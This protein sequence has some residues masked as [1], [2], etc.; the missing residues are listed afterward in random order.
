MTAWSM[1]EP[2]SAYD[3]LEAAGAAADDDDRVVA[4]R[5][6]TG[7]LGST[8]PSV[9]GPQAAG[10]RLEHPEHDPRI[11]DEER[12]DRAGQDEAAQ[13]ARGRR[14]RR[15]AARRA[16]STPR[17][18]SRPRPRRA[19]SV[20]VDDDRRLALE[21]DVEA[22]A[23]QALAEDALA[24]ARTAA[25]SKV[26]TIALELRGGEVGEQR[27]AA[28]ASS[29]SS[30]SAMR[31]IV[32]RRRACRGQTPAHHA[33]VTRDLD[34]PPSGGAASAR[35]DPCTPRRTDD[36]DPR[37]SDRAAGA[38]RRCSP[39]SMPPAS[40]GSPSASVEVDFPAGPCHRP[41]GRGR[42]RVLRRSPAA[43]ARRP[44]RR[45]D[46]AAGPGRLLRRAVGA[47]RRAA[48]SPRSSPTARRSASA[49]RLGLRGG[50]HASEPRSPWRSCAGSP[51][52]LRDAHEPT[53]TDRRAAQRHGCRS[54]PARRPGRSPAC[55]ATS[56][57]R[58]GSSWPLAPDRIATSVSATGAA[59]R[60]VRGAWR[61]RAGHR[62]RLVLR[63]L[64]GR[65]R[66]G[67]RGGR[68][69]ARARRA[70]RGPTTASVRVRMGLHTGEIETAGTDVIGYAINRTAR[71]A[72]GRPRRPGPA[73]SDA[74]RSLVAGRAA[75][76]RHPPRPRG[77]SAQGPA[78]PGAA[79]PARDRRPARRLPAAAFAR[80]PAQQP[81]DPA[82]DL[83]RARCASWPRRAG[84][85]WRPA[86]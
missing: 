82:D 15:S 72:G 64:P 35:D 73:S 58:P 66:R 1:P 62:R 21:D 44:R 59:A 55:S 33:P 11:R 63:D 76:R 28:I 74:T 48:R 30:R 36:A 19:R 46:R 43:G 29:S 86:C 54:E 80:C 6:R 53:G 24:L 45:D 65:H 60:R 18:R 2:R 40:R 57:A 85:S 39:A 81:A 49:S 37:P 83:R 10:L 16:G 27:E 77:A 5:E 31:G 68:R 70:S 22:G 69:P 20:A 17:R 84:C 34:A 38:P 25:S 4:G 3:D 50:H 9:R 12:L 71:I 78:R 32:P 61:P 26:W 52:R 23:G 41:P 79:G 8:A 75:G 47:R 56:R 51:A 14:R 13:R 7:R 67:R 42:D